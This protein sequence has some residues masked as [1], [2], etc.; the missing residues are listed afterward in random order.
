MLD[1]ITGLQPSFIQLRDK[2]TINVIQILHPTFQLHER[3]PFFFAL[4]QERVPLLRACHALA[5]GASCAC[6]AAESGATKLWRTAIRPLTKD[7]RALS[8]RDATLWAQEPFDFDFCL[9]ARPSVA[10]SSGANEAAAEPE[11]GGEAAPWLGE[12]EVV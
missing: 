3:L 5:H 7:R 9:M 12:L 1:L 2:L 6:K 4:L 10:A 11:G 8:V